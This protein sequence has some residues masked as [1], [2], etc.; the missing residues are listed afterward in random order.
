MEANLSFC[1]KR[2]LSHLGQA[3]I[4]SLPFADECFD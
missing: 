3:T 2:R 4:V 1:R